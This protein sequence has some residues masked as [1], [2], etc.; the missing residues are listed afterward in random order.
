MGLISGLVTGVV[1]W[2]LAPVR[3]VV[4]V[5][6]QIEQEAA[7]QWTDP[8]LVETELENVAARRAAGEISEA[9]AEELEEELVQRLL[10]RGGSDG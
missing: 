5:A 9:E 7:R 1:T 4:W 3:G 2:P 8:A 6:E 10:Q